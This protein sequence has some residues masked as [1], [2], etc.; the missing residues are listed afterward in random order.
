MTP[1]TRRAFMLFHATLGGVLLLNGVMAVSHALHELD[2]RHGHLAMVGSLEA[3][4]A[5]LFL[6]PRT[7]RWG[8]AALLVVLLGGVAM[9]L[10]KGEWQEL[11][12]LIYATGVWLV[13]LNGA[14]WGTRTANEG[15]ITRE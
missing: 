7:V 1:T 6:I 5:L 11:H 8:G 13:M 15:T 4:G 2:G 9:H 14:E 12:Y 3:L 10:S